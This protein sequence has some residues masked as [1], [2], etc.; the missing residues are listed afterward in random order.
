MSIKYVVVTGGS[1]RV[2]G[3]VVRQLLNNYEVIVAD[4]VRVILMLAM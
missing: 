4:L 1:G 2:G 3:Y